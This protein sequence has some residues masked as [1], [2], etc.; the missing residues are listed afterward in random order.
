MQEQEC[1]STK[2]CQQD[3]EVILKKKIKGKEGKP[4]SCYAI[5]KDAVLYFCKSLAVCM[6][7]FVSIFRN[8]LKTSCNN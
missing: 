6:R 8:A 1:I 5:L 3:G 4:I 2:D 7:S